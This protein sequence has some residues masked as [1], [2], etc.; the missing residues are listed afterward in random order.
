MGTPLWNVNVENCRPVVGNP[1]GRVPRK[2]P[3]TS[4]HVEGLR[5]NALHKNLMELAEWI[6]AYFTDPET[7]IVESCVANGKECL[8]FVVCITGEWF[9]CVNL[10]IPP[11]SLHLY[12]HFSGIWHT[13]EIP[14]TLKLL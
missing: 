14:R 7:R 11:P 2:K 6:C 12:F 5:Y 13:S 1:G 8:L 4:I 9:E 3:L 10:T